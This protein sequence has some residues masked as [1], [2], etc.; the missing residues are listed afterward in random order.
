MEQVVLVT[1]ALAA[2]RAGG[3]GPWACAGLRP[4]HSRC[5]PSGAQPD[6]NST[7]RAIVDAVLLRVSGSPWFNLSFD[8]IHTD[9]LGELPREDL[10]LW[11]ARLRLNRR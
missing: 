11:A 10:R 1:C 4:R 2:W 8:F 9:E 3:W 6:H 7:I 5:R